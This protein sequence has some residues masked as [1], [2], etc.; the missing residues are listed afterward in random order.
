MY[1]PL[2][3][4]PIVIT[5]IAT[6]AHFV[7]NPA[8]AS[9]ETKPLTDYVKVIWGKEEGLPQESV[10]KVLQTR[11]GYI[12]VGTQEGLARFDGVHFTIFNTQNSPGLESDNIHDLAQD[13]EGNL[14]IFAN[15]GLS[16]YRDGVIRNFTPRGE[17]SGDRVSKIWI[18]RD[19]RLY[20]AS[21]D[22]Y[23]RYEN[24]QLVSL[25][26]SKDYFK[27]DCWNSFDLA[28]NDIWGLTD[29][30][31]V[32][33][34]KN[35]HEIDRTFIKSK[36]TKIASL[37]PD[38]TG[39][40]WA[41]GKS[42]YYFDGNRF[43]P[44]AHPEVFAHH[45]VEWLT[46]DQHN[47]LWCIAGDA[48]LSLDGN[49]WK[50]RKIVPG[51]RDHGYR[52]SVD[53]SGNA[54]A[55]KEGSQADTLLICADGSIRSIDI[56]E[57]LP[58]E[59]ALP[60]MEDAQGSIWIGTKSGLVALKDPSCHTYGQADGVP[61]SPVSVVTQDNAGLIWIAT[62][63]G[64]LG[65]LVN[66]RF[67]PCTA[68]EFVNNP[69]IS[70]CSGDGNTIWISTRDTVYHFDGKHAT[71]MLHVNVRVRDI[72]RNALCR[73][74]SGDIWFADMYDLY[75]FHNG[76]K[77]HYTRADG[78]DSD[79]VCLAIT[80]DG[81]GGVWVGTL[82]GCTHFDGHR[83]IKYDAKDG[84]PTV[85]VIAIHRDE[86]GEVW[87]GTWGGGLF[88]WK[89]GKIAAITSR[90]GLYA[91]SIHQILEDR[92]GYFWIGSAKGIFRV[93][94]QTLDSFANG[95]KA[96]ISC[97]AYGRD[98]GAGGGQ[99]HG[100]TQPSACVSRDGSLW[101]ATIGGVVHVQPARKTAWTVPFL[102]EQANINGVDV[103]VT[104]HVT[105]GP[106]RGDIEVHYSA[107]DYASPQK[108]HF[109]YRLTGF[110]KGWTVAS[111]RRVAYY[112][113]VPPG[114]YN[115]VV[116]A[117]N[118][119]GVLNVIQPALTITLQP[120]FYQ[121]VWFK[122]LCVL[123]IA[124]ACLAAY[125]V[126]V[127]HLQAHNRYLEA[128]IGERT[129]ELTDANEELRALHEELMAQNESLQTVQ[130]AVEAQNE[131]LTNVKAQLEVRNDDLAVANT[132]LESLVTLD[133]LTG[134][135]NHR[136]FQEHLEQQWSHAQRHS[137]HL[138]LILMDVDRFKQYN[139]T[140]GHPAGDDVLKNVG[141]ILLDCARAGDFV[142]RYG[143]E[144]FV[145]VMPQTDATSAVTVAERFRA[146][147][148]QATWPLREV[149]A[150]FGIAS[151]SVATDDRAT[152]IAEA[153]RALYASKEAGRNR[154]T[155]IADV[156][157]IAA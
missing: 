87:L 95:V 83:F 56:P 123:A 76:V 32:Y 60:V 111:T 78:F 98:E 52:L 27:Q 1:R 146:G 58:V 119:D 71:P 106:G 47:V 113:N 92:D 77:T 67:V 105:A 15:S 24:G 70:M 50:V 14:W 30:N 2:K 93:S 26:S 11:D 19:R 101:F 117:Y 6:F 75:R 90:D 13:G 33:E 118:G 88:R 100:G 145:I 66:G 147:I 61:D 45:D 139:D 46:L 143:G 150:S 114:T 79:L 131:E 141:R 138:S 22:L 23:Y 133:G 18:G 102:I 130:A 153:D 151:M 12:W 54:C 125:R 156:D 80:P 129:E 25:F 142:A 122:S 36:D 20:V 64:Q 112:T 135:K 96:P 31:R 44:Y 5:L 134:L 40:L 53:A 94:K 17:K 128:K 51:L 104:S 81:N 85:P 154:V 28:P 149:T 10:K 9:A 86:N 140:Y 97:D 115:F 42:V 41:A 48:I 157:R 68:K 38:G 65:Q 107:L 63:G 126:R 89:N 127:Q 124:L 29:G 37:S 73:D 82:E 109:E 8:P 62:D 7:A 136:A 120:H 110:D 55:W 148:E 137:S 3:L 108:V 99:C 69:V 132:R 72:A 49:T 16:R 21:D 59:W 84:L 4:V 57:H 116:Q 152:L 121:T 43:V 103:P 144:E 155:H 35:G 91:N 34:F 74:S 39:R